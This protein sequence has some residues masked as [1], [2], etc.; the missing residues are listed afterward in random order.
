M[1]SRALCHMS[2]WYT[3]LLDTSLVKLTVCDG[4]AHRSF[5][6]ASNALPFALSP[7]SLQVLYHLTSS[8]SCKEFNCHLPRW[9]SFETPMEH[10][11]LTLMSSNFIF[12]KARPVLAV[13]TSNYYFIVYCL[14][15]FLENTLHWGMNLAFSFNAINPALKPEPGT[16]SF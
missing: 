7:R 1:T 5:S 16:H 9:D 15:L 10:K 12:T 14:F 3:R 2:P 13:V 4:R 11:S 8:F 6:K